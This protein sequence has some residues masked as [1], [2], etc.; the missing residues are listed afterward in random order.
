MSV[1]RA[2]RATDDIGT[3][4]YNQAL[5]EKRAKAVSEVLKSKGLGSQRIEVNWEGEKTPAEDNA[6]R[7]GRTKNRRVE[8]KVIE[9]ESA[10]K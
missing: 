2:E 4:A 3:D 9:L 1:V 5:S 8:V 10:T 7:E 6:T